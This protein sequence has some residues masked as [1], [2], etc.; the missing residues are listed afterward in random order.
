MS[1]FNIFKK[2]T[3]KDDIFTILSNRSPDF[4]KG[5]E[6]PNKKS[7]SENIKVLSNYPSRN[8]IPNLF[9]LKI[10]RIPSFIFSVAFFTCIGWVSMN[11]QDTIMGIFRFIKISD[12]F[13][14]Y[15]NY[16]EIP[17]LSF[18]TILGIFIS[19]VY[20]IAIYQRL[21][22]RFIDS[23]KNDY[24]TLLSNAIFKVVN[25]SSEKTIAILSI[26]EKVASVIFLE[27]KEGNIIPTVINIGTIHRED[28]N[29]KVFQEY[30]P[31]KN[32]D[33]YSISLKNNFNKTYKVIKLVRDNNK[34]IVKKQ[35]NTPI[36][37]L[38]ICDEK[39]I[40]DMDN[41]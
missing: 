17:I 38:N 22:R 10:I 16:N 36:Y 21:S 24:F 1:I 37:I 33:E 20:N 14:I 15:F 2:N 6:E 28:K 4:L 7:V 34:I 31:L 30:Y 19:I 35:D 9:F 27:N 41:I 39:I 26:K 32:Y 25:D 29:T 12:S 23:F 8:K 11:Q 3:F 13:N 40:V 18:G 5:I